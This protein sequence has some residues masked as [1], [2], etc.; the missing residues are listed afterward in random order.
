MSFIILIG[1]LGINLET[2]SQKGKTSLAE[3]VD[4]VVDLRTDLRK[5][6]QFEL[7][8]Q[9]RAK[10]KDLGIQLEDKP[11]GTIWKIKN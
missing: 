6:K 1:I 7:A 10:L 3:L 4:L 5:V 8:D 9:L 11:E 2:D